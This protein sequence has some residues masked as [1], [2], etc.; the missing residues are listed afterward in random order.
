VLMELKQSTYYRFLFRIKCGEKLVKL[1]G[2]I[3][4]LSVDR[5]II[6]R[7]SLQT[8]GLYCTCTTDLQV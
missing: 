7:F 8:V 2:F 4:L 5:K 3:E 6:L 1:R